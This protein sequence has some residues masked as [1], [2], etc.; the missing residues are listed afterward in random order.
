[1]SIDNLDTM[2]VESKGLFDNIRGLVDQHI[3]DCA[4]Q[5]LETPEIQ[6]SIMASLQ[7][8]YVKYG[9]KLIRQLSPKYSDDIR[10][11]FLERFAM[12]LEIELE[13]DNGTH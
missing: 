12:A 5:G 1:M 2:I 11:T 7:L 4:R 6:A 8:A 10:K 3:E 9:V 13:D